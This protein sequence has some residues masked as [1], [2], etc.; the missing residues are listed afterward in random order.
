[1]AQ[2]RENEKQTKQAQILGS[3]L[4]DFTVSTALNEKDH[5]ILQD[6]VKVLKRLGK[7]K[8]FEVSN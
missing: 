2:I 5:F 1:M 3:R 6:A 7:E 4:D 8:I